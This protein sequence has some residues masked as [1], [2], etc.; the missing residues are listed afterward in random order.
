MLN[1][2]ISATYHR[3]SFVVLAMSGGSD[4]CGDTMALLL[5]ADSRSAMSDY[6]ACGP[7]YRQQPPL[8]G[9]IRQDRT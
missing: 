4:P 5:G 9:E 7:L 2:H 6:P 3:A 1:S 8:A